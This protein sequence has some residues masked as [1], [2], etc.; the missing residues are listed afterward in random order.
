MVA[1]QIFFKIFTPIG[2]LVV[3]LGGGFSFFLFSPR[4]LRTISPI[5][6]AYFFRWVGSTTNQVETCQ[7][8]GHIWT[9]WLKSPC[10]LWNVSYFGG[11]KLFVLLWIEVFVDLI[12]QVVDFLFLWAYL[13]HIDGDWEKSGKPVHRQLIPLFTR[14]GEQQVTSVGI[15]VREWFPEGCPIIS[16]TC[17]ISVFIVQS[18][19]LS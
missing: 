7:C 8:N 10:L 13:T 15:H 9:K 14:G 16:E 1:T 11:W 2:G 4:K 19:V 6:Q 17:C 12:E 3:S 5:W 18:A